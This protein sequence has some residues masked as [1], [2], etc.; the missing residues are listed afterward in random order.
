MQ[1]TTLTVRGARGEA[2]QLIDLPV[3]ASYRSVDADL[4]ERAVNVAEAYARFAHGS[5]AL[6]QIPDFDDAVA[7]HRLIDAIE[8]SA[9]F[10][11]RIDL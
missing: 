9:A 10:G 2:V 8:R 3:P 7:R 5:E 11:T 4:P 6:D 1:A